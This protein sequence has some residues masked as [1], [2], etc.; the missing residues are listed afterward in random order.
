MFKQ[1]YIQKLAFDNIRRQ[2][3]FYK[4]IFVSLLTT[5]ILSSMIAI[6]YASYEEISYRE[7][8]TCYGKWG[9]VIDGESEN[10]FKILKE[11]FSIVSGLIYRVCEVNYQG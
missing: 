8:Y 3:K 5:F 9:L 11:D 6:L 2:R 7:K 10:E 1:N 4:F